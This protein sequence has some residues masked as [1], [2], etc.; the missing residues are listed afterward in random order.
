HKLPNA[1]KSHFYAHKQSD[2]GH[3]LP[4]YRLGLDD[5]IE[6]GLLGLSLHDLDGTLDSEERKLSWAEHTLGN[7]ASAFAGLEKAETIL[8]GAQWLFDSYSSRDELL[9]FVQ[10]MVV[11]EIL[12]GDKNA[13]DKIGLG[14]LLRNRCAYLIG[15]SQEERTNILQ[16]FNKIYSV[17]SQ[18]VHAGKHRL[19]LEE[20][21][22][23]RRLQWMCRRVIDKEVDL[24]KANPK[25]VA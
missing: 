8:L 19:T 3:F 20:R 24:L 18:I 9:S 17:R 6:R 14:S 23:F 25:P 4:E 10:A 2:N 11:L 15:N 16:D 7:M 12:L 1:Q 5:P 13:S 22:L 21:S